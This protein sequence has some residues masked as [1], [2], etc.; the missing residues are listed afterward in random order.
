MM[1]KD[2]S[3]SWVSADKHQIGTGRSLKQASEY[4]D[5]C[6]VGHS[7][8]VL[9]CMNRENLTLLI[10][11]RSDWDLTKICSSS[12]QVWVEPHKSI[13]CIR[14]ARL[15]IRPSSASLTEP[16][17]LSNDATFNCYISQACIC[18][19]MIPSKQHVVWKAPI[20]STTLPNLSMC[21]LLPLFLYDRRANTCLEYWSFQNAFT[22]DF[23]HFHHPKRDW[24]WLR[25]EIGW[26]LTWMMLEI[27]NEDLLGN[28][29]QK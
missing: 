29:M 15:Y 28:C 9:Q 20:W 8:R 25:T 23:T 4:T 7:C 27:R 11:L 2:Q 18:K 22:Q 13:E 14:T 19:A 16:G 21:F 6:S 5:A 26:E 10:V 1:Q 12:M 24:D 3:Y 17:A